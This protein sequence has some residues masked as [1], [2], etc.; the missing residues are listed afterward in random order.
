MK[1][2][3]PQ[4]K[5]TQC[6]E[7]V[8]EVFKK[9]S[10][11]RC[12]CAKRRMYCTEVTGKAL[13]KYLFDKRNSTTDPNHFSNRKK[14]RICSNLNDIIKRAQTEEE[15]KDTP[16]LC[17]NSA[18]TVATSRKN[19]PPSTNNSDTMVQPNIERSRSQRLFMRKRI[20]VTDCT[21]KGV[22]KVVVSIDKEKHEIDVQ[23]Q[24]KS[25][26]KTD[27]FKDDVLKKYYKLPFGK[28]CMNERRRRMRKIGKEILSACVDRKLF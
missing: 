7:E 28:I 6:D 15:E 19:L 9:Y 10:H 22:K 11:R 1:K 20:P 4:R 16:L 8:K 23:N 13:N 26:S 24:I 2:T 3:P 14:Y 21:L 17:N 27:T 12:T 18:S 5:H 25:T